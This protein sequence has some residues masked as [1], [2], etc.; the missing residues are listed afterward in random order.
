MI[1]PVTASILADLPL[2]MRLSLMTFAPGGGNYD[3]AKVLMVRRRKNSPVR[4]KNAVTVIMTTRTA[5][6]PFSRAASGFRQEKVGK[7]GHG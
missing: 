5:V 3:A 7:G 2:I 1:M 4:M 6:S